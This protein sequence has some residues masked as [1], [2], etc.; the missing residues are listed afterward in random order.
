VLG[1]GPGL[2]LRLAAAEVEP[3][4][5]VRGVD[6]S[7]LMV[8]ARCVSLVADS[9]VEL[10]DGTSERTGCDSALVDAAIS[11]NNIMLWNRPAGVAELAR[12]LRP[13]GRLAITVMM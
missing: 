12:V 3:L 8:T 11:V 4:G 13:G 6:P 1:V 9:I 5:H 2:G 10:A 7:P